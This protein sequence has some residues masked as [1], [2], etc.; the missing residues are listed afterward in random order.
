MVKTRNDFDAIFTPGISLTDA[1]NKAKTTIKYNN[2]DL[3]DAE[4]AIFDSALLKEKDAS[5]NELPKIN[6]FKDTAALL[7]NLKVAQ[8]NLE[9]ERKSNTN[10]TDGGNKLLTALLGEKINNSVAYQLINP[11]GVDQIIKDYQAIQFRRLNKT[12]EVKKRSLEIELDSILKKGEEQAREVE[13]ARKIM[14]EGLSVAEAEDY[15][16][17]LKAV[18]KALNADLASGQNGRKILDRAVQIEKKIA[19][20]IYKKD[21]PGDASSFGS[22]IATGIKNP[23]SDKIYTHPTYLYE[24]LPYQMKELFAQF[25]KKKLFALIENKFA[26]EPVK[27]TKIK[28]AFERVINAEVKLETKENFPFLHPGDMLDATPEDISAGDYT[29]TGLD[30]IVKYDFPDDFRNQRVSRGVVKLFVPGNMENAREG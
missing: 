14:E 24:G 28:K 12:L 13:E 2:E 11:K 8:A 20:V 7:D 6:D 26:S 9:T 29:M 27:I 3:D 4:K 5:N 19:N 23:Y 1:I 18:V 15:K 22:I 10:L 21:T 30:T 25:D 16:D 17:K